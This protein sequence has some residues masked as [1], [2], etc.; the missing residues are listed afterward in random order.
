M[1]GEGMGMEQK[2]MSGKNLDGQKKAEKSLQNPKNHNER[3]T[4]R[5]S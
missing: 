5:S 3:Y 4:I 1:E 2:T